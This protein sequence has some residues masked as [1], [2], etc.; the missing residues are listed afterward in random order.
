ML[1]VP[2]ETGG[3]RLNLCRNRCVSVKRLLGG[4]PSLWVH[5]AANQRRNRRQECYGLEACPEL[6]ALSA[7]VHLVHWHLGIGFD[8]GKVFGCIL[9]HL[10]DPLTT[11]SLRTWRL[12]DRVPVKP[13][14]LFLKQSYIKQ[15]LNFNVWRKII[16]HKLLHNHHYVPQ[17][18]F[19]V[20]SPC[21]IIFHIKAAELSMVYGIYHLAIDNYKPTIVMVIYGTTITIYVR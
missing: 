19:L 17:L 9:L 6:E 4:P 2:S 15:C 21:S 5:V 3:I 20:K 10:C 16:T 7:C 18:N 8:W 14:A 1:P 11:G 12:V 13:H